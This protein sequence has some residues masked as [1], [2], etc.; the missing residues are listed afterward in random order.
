MGLI[1]LALIAPEPR[2]AHCPDGL[3]VRFQRVSPI[4]ARDFRAFGPLTAEASDWVSP[5]AIFKRFDR[6]AV[7]DDAAFLDPAIEA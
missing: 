5:L 1:P 3:A 4:N 2:H 6:I 7:A